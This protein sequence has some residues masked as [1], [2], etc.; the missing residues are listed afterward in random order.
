LV[1]KEIILFIF[2]SIRTLRLDTARRSEP[3]RNV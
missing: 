3:T 2:I 1:V